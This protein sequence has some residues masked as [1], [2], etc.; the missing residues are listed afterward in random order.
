METTIPRFEVQV[1]NADVKWETG[2]EEWAL[3]GVWQATQQAEAER[4]CTHLMKA[5]YMA[6][7]IARPEQ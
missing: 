4:Q 1:L 7:V 2:C 6:R 3:V 5:G